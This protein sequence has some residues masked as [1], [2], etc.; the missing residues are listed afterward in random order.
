MRQSISNLWNTN[1]ITFFTK[2]KSFK[3]SLIKNMSVQVKRSKI[4]PFY[5]TPKRVNNISMV[6]KLKDKFGKTVE[7]K[8]IFKPD[9][10]T[11]LK[12]THYNYSQFYLCLED[13]RVYLMV[14]SDD[15]LYK[16]VFW[17]IEDIVT[18]M[19]VK[20]PKYKILNSSF[21]KEQLN[22]GMLQ[23][24]FNVSKS[25]DHGTLWK[26]SQKSRKP[27]LTEEDDFFNF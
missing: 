9:S 3:K 4:V 22:N 6:N 19:K 12:I 5:L 13:D 27:F 25:K 7:G 1:P 16:E 20:N 15:K 2:E 24:K 8:K 21:I 18:S 26:I 17:N 14:I 11:T 10:I 23:V